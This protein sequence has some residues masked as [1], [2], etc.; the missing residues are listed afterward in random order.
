M[1]DLT[2][3]KQINDLDT[4]TAAFIMSRVKSVFD[5]P[6]TTCENISK[7]NELFKNLMK[8]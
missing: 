2:T 5:N 3:E 7:H 8:K 4:E 1:T 6:E